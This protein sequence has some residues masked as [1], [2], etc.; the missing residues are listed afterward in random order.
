MDPTAI[1]PTGVGFVIVPHD[2]QDATQ[3]GIY[4]QM[5]AMGKLFGEERIFIEKRFGI[6]LVVVLA[7]L[8]G[9]GSATGGVGNDVVPAAVSATHQVV[10][11]F[12]GSDALWRWRRWWIFLWH[13]A[14][15]HH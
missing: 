12:G 4:R 14:F 15:E 11:P 8:H 7:L 10:N 9:K 13:C 6:V 2:G 1:G 5:T 3:V